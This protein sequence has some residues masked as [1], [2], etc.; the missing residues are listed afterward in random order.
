MA[1][2]NSYPSVTDLVVTWAKI[3]TDSFNFG[4]TVV[5]QTT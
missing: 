4:F 1:G 3:S 5:L 2:A